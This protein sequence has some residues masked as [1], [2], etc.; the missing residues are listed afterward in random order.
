MTAEKS[1]GDIVSDSLAARIRR[2]PVCSTQAETSETFAGWL[3]ALESDAAQRLRVITKA[4]PKVVALFDGIAQGSPY[5]WDLTCAD[6]ERLLRVLD[7]DPDRYFP[8]LLD[9]VMQ[10]IRSGA[11]DA[12]AMRALRQMKT[13]AA[14]LIALADIGGLWTT[15]QVIQA[16]TEVADA[17]VRGAVRH[18]L[19]GAVAKG[20][21][22]PADASTPEIGSGY[23]V[24]A[25]GKMGAFELNYSS[26]I[27]L[28]VFFD[29]RAPALSPEIEPMP[30][31]VR[32]TRGLVKLLQERTADGYVF[33]TDLRLRPDP[34]STQIAISIDAALDY[35][36]TAG[37]NWE[38][39]AMIKAR[40]CAGDIAPGENL[41]GNLAPFIWRKYLDY[42]AIVSVQAMKKDIHAYKGHGSIAVE[43]HNIKLGRGGI[44]EIEF[45]VQTQQ[46]IAGGRHPGL[47]GRQT[48]PMLEKLAES[49]WISTTARDDL[50]QAYL[51]L[52][53]VEHRLQ[54][55]A[56]EQTQTLPATPEAFAQ[57]SRFLGYATR[58]E[59][60]EDLLRQL[61]IVQKHYEQ[62]F[63]KDAASDDAPLAFPE[64]RDDPQTLH[65]LAEM[66][67]PNPLE[68]SARIRTWFE[69]PYRPLHEAAARE[70]LHAVLPDFLT[71]IARL[72]NADA[73]LS[74]FDH[75]LSQLHG[76]GRLFSLLRQRPDLVGFIVL[77]IGTAP[78]LAGILAQ[79]PQVIDSLIE[80]NFFGILPNEDLLQRTLD[81]SL[82]L[83][84]SFEDV[85]DRVRI[86]AQEQMFLIGARILAETVSA[87]QAGE[88]FTDLADICIRAL[89]AAVQDR[90][91]ESYGR[92]RGQEIALLALGKLGG[93]EMTATS[94]LDLIVIYDHD[95]AEPESDG[96]RKLYG[97]QYFAR[98]TQRL[99][100]ALTAQT[101]FGVLYNVDMR[102]RPSGR[103]GPLATHVDSFASYQET[104]AWTWEHMALTRARVLSG[105]PEFAARI[106]A[107]I[108]AALNRER[109]KAVT[110]G[111][112]FEMRK[113]IAA[114]KSESNPW[115]IKYAA[116]GLVD[117]EFITQY[118]QL[119]HGHEMPD[120]RDHATLRVLQ[121]ALHRGV[122][123][124]AH[125]DVLI[126]AA[127]LYQ[128]L[129]QLLR[130]CLP[131]RFEPKN[132][133]P[134]LLRLL[135]RVADLPDFPSLDAY[136]VE[137]Q[138]QVRE[139]FNALLAP[140]GEALAAN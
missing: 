24:V 92:V 67:F 50:T 77:I 69:T 7:A 59:F 41:L 83:A 116:G 108:A 51:F 105:S 18:L 73:A 96:P 55:V 62:L 16:L 115:D 86:F 11:D 52:R 13:E 20:Q 91:V 64:G 78:R 120:L 114:E 35:Y 28:I 27:D 101:N 110:A 72:E 81:T 100:G 36:E 129:T 140:E 125:A 29:P 107:T 103:S 118:L 102:L 2:A 94:D 124:K 80:P 1:R 23:F 109:D 12:A 39:A 46:L 71:R 8:A 3:A 5:L 57:F 135:S 60:A 122:L 38:R 17:A 132:A 104:E 4:Q 89:F 26:D 48:L 54:M 139:C 14:L 136:L 99:I 43:G 123:S 10:A 74:T 87:E 42:A 31:F 47:R 85:L 128:E 82:A 9:N 32:I 131:G 40:V 112:V 79:F 56:D 66:G 61:R 34:S 53:D 84:E 88:W 126:P 76:R 45:F 49:Q 63:E 137:T 65:R 98:L 19:N 117:V 68:V 37:R 113:A 130:L 97:A 127:K 58:D 95:A 121:N 70:Q 134:V 33:R 90:F 119:V 111:D 25:M 44:R 21:L 106:E 93:C 133:G 6:P 15:V 22:T 138:R 30:F 75:F